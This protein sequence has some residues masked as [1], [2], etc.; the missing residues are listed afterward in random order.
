MVAG[1][2]AAAAVADL[3]Q[4]PL[5]LFCDGVVMSILGKLDVR[6]LAVA[7]VVCTRWLTVAS[8]DR[9]W[10]PKCQELWLGKAHL[11]RISKNRITRNDMCDHA[12]EFHFTAA[13][14]AYWRNLDPY[15]G[16]DGAPMRR[17]F[18]DD[19]SVTADPDDKVWGGHESSYTVVTG[20]L[21]DNKMREHY[22]R[23]NRWPQMSVQ[24]KPD[25]SWELA[26]HLYSY[27]SIPDAEKEDGT[28]PY[29]P[30]F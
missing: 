27:S 6:S 5:V 14:P 23:I 10:G 17:Y 1:E 18:H 11:P 29:V 28:G 7:C 9:L 24:R 30:M 19:G 22:V 13:A 16:A 26:N 20:L 21:A 3:S 12:W 15:W 8:T 2:S 25:W 4:D